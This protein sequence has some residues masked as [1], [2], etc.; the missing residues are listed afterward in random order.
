MK[1][2]NHIL[3]DIREYLYLEDGPISI[4]FFKQISGS[5]SRF[6]NYSAMDGYNKHIRLYEGAIKYAAF[7][8]R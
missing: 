8:F 1:N 5:Y 2:A 7:T 6:E 4:K 3:S